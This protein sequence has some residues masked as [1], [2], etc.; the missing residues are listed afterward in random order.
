MG[1]A[2]TLAASMIPAFMFGKLPGYIIYKE[3]I[4]FIWRPSDPDKW[5]IPWTVQYCF[6]LSPFLALNWTLTNGYKL[7][8][9]QK[10]SE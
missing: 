1:V 8:S 3:K 5:S 7:L 10:Q 4:A 2:L 9:I 6:L